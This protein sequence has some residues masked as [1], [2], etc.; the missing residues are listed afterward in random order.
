MGGLGGT[1]ELGLFLAGALEF[2]AAHPA[3]VVG[4]GPVV[5]LVTGGLIGLLVERMRSNLA[6]QRESEERYALAAKGANDGLWDWDLRTDRVHY[7]ERWRD[8]LGY[9][10]EEIT[11]TPEDWLERIHPDDV[12]NVR[13]PRPRR[14]HP[15]GACRT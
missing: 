5:L 3:V 2:D 4:M 10:P 6:R 1:L 9:R 11:D 8:I 7:S 12:G 14:R 15:P 13:S